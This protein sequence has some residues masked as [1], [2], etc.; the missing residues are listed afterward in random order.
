MKSHEL[1]NKMI[2]SIISIFEKIHDSYVVHR[3]I[4][5]DNF[6]MNRDEVCLIDFGFAYTIEDTIDYKQNEHLVGSLKFCSYYIHCGE[7]Y[8][9]RDDLIS[10][11]YLFLYIIHNMLPWDNI[12]KNNDI[13]HCYKETHIEHPNNIQR[14]KLKDISNL[15]NIYNG[16]IIEFLNLC[17]NYHYNDK[18][19]YYIL[20]Q[21]FL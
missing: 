1:S 21:L 10:L 17:Y 11:G 18:P 19:F 3:D 15:K 6:M 13:S 16:N 14:K 2:Y 7:P 9:F 20:Y 5:L 8:S 4:K 12:A